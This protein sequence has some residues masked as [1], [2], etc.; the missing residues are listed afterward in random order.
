MATPPPSSRLTATA[1]ARRVLFGAT[2]EP[3]AWRR[4]CRA[5]PGA[6]LSTDAT[7]IGR[8]PRRPRQVPC[9]ESVRRQIAPCP[10][11]CSCARPVVPSICHLQCL[12]APS[13]FARC[14]AS[15]S[16]ALAGCP[17]AKPFDS[18]H[19]ATNSNATRPCR[20]CIRAPQA[21]VLLRVRLRVPLP[22]RTPPR[23]A[24]SACAHPLLRT[25]SRTSTP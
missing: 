24:Q 14:P 9:V 19:T 11:R 15:S 21:S 22:S 17:C 16:G 4:L 13:G 7:W 23:A 2:I 20:V 25:C 18:H 10:G 5:A 6:A 1:A 12:V 3:L 8:R